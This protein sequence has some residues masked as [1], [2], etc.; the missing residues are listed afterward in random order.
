M[1]GAAAAKGCTACNA[2]SR[3]RWRRGNGARLCASRCRRA[4]ANERRRKTVRLVAGQMFGLRSP[5]KTQWDT[6]FADVYLDAGASVP[7][8]A[9]YEERSIYVID[10]EID[11]AGDRF[12]PENCWYSSRATGSPSA[13]DE[14]PFR[15]SRRRAHG[16]AASHLVEF[17]VIAQRAHRSGEG[18]LEI[19]PLRHR[20]GR[21]QR[22]HS[23]AGKISVTPPCAG[24]TGVQRCR[25]DALGLIRRQL[26][27][28]LAIA[29]HQPVIGKPALVD[30]GIRSNQ[31]AIRM[32]REQV[33]PFRRQ[34][35]AVAG[36]AAAIGQLTDKRGYFTSNSFTRAGDVENPVCAQMIFAFGCVKTGGAG[37]PRRNARAG[38]DSC[39][40]RN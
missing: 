6:I 12:G 9:D 5:V 20:A 15:H 34:R 32:T 39:R 1:S 19:R 4:A 26:H 35:A 21:Q 22:I 37:L 29:L 10:G 16:W 17:R 36:D 23:A 8:D 24:G 2:G 28:P 27:E 3:C 33:A 14:K 31:K 40:P 18:G 38:T 25:C 30:P 11:I 13:R 7:L